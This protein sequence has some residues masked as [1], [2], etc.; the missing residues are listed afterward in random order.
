MVWIFI[1]VLANISKKSK[2]SCGSRDGIAC[3]TGFMWNNNTKECEKCP[4]GH[5]G[6]K[7]S[8]TCKYPS[9]G[10][11]CQQSCACREEYCSPQNG[12]TKFEDLKSEHHLTTEYIY[13]TRDSTSYGESKK[14]SSEANLSHIPDNN[15]IIFFGVFAL[16]SV[17]VV[18]FG[19]FVAAYFY[20]QC[21]LRKLLA[22]QATS[23]NIPPLT[24]KA[25][26]SDF[27]RIFVSPEIRENI[28]T[29]HGYLHPLSESDT[30][31]HEIDST[32][33]EFNTPT[34]IDPEDERQKNDNTY[35]KPVMPHEYV[36]IVGENKVEQ[37]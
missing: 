34:W 21:T 18:L 9:F 5:F 14:P 35:L 31:Y 15:N 20:K 17:V 12:C 29:D 22:R 27:E 1:L 25:L 33:V 26:N 4:V 6:I 11:G 23:P 13:V 28:E 30:Q 10:D 16:S 2:S 36:D 24:Y 3:C 7:C 8:R 19:I 37:S 32:S